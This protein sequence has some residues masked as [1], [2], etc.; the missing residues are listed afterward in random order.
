M[1]QHVSSWAKLKLKKN[2]AAWAT[3]NCPIVTKMDTAKN[4][5][6]SVTCGRPPK[7]TFILLVHVSKI[8]ASNNCFFCLNMLCFAKTKH[9]ATKCVAMSQAQVETKSC[10]VSKTI[11]SACNKHGHSQKCDADCHMWKTTQKALL[12]CMYMRHLNDIMYI[13]TSIIWSALKTNY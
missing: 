3:T 7:Q 11:L 1:Q 13:R 12:F 2:P 5:M 6:L 9:I 8:D 4:V 10:C